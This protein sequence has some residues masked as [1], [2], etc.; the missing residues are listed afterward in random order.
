MDGV[1]I[2]RFLKD[3][4]SPHFGS[5]WVILPWCFC[6]NAV[7]FGKRKQQSLM[8]MCSRSLSAPLD[9]ACSPAR[10]CWVL[11]NG[12]EEKGD[13]NTKECSVV[14]SPSPNI[15]H[16][17]KW[18]LLTHC[19]AG[20]SLYISSHLNNHIDAFSSLLFFLPYFHLLFSWGGCE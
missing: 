3:Y 2:F 13:L 20:G 17:Q 1:C 12:W 8:S 15:Q 18:L 6:E 11:Q 14:C 5:F 16:G 9:R 7:C 19:L 4:C 10:G